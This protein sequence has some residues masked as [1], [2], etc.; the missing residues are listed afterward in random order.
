MFDELVTLTNFPLEIGS[1]HHDLGNRSL[2]PL[3]FF[4]LGGGGHRSALYWLGT[5]LCLCMLCTVC[6]LCMLK[7]LVTEEEQSKKQA[8]LVCV[9]TGEAE[10]EGY[11]GLLAS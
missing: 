6:C 3:P 5:L 9:L 11:W 2:C 10:A 4:G 1:F 7:P 8:L